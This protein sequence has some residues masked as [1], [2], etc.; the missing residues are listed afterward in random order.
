MSKAI[1]FT[2]L[3]LAGLAAVA[4]CSGG[5]DGGGGGDSDAAGAV[6][7]ERGVAE[8]APAP[9]PA[10]D[11]AV[12]SESG[13]GAVAVAQPARS[14]LPEVGP[15][16]IRTASLR[17]SVAD[18]RFEDAVAR[19][20]TIAAG[21]GGFVTAS[22]ASKGRGERLVRGTLVLR[23]PGEA[24]ARV[25][26]QLRGLGRVEGREESG[27]DVSAQLV[28]LQSRARHLEAVESQLLELLQRAANVAE[29]L[30]VQ[31]NLN[32]V[33]LELEQVR[34]QLGYLDDQVSYATISLD[35]RERNAPAA[36]GG[37]EGWGIVETWRDAARGFVRVTG[38]V[39]VGIA[40]ALPV[41]LLVGL[42]ALG[43]RW[44]NVRRRARPS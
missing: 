4:G 25:L 1:A 34:G 10:G 22:T 5:D 13:G 41:L 16:V 7:M 24:Y 28:D 20:R 29:A 17:L 36:G 37:D 19:A 38:A 40:T 42:L 3:T 12:S 2:I 39:V 11:Q 35:L 30:A 27:Q 15:R 44:A 26:D 43:A 33:Q 9:A 31:S 18:G 21:V 6:T 14:S 23:V 32:A 8:G